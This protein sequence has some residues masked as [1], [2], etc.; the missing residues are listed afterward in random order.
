MPKPRPLLKTLDP[1]ATALGNLGLR[2][3]FVEGTEGLRYVRAFGF[4]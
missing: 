4:F 1:D 3:I 2:V